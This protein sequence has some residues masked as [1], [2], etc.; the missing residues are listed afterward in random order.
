M[1]LEKI[2]IRKQKSF[3]II[4]RIFCCSNQTKSQ[5]FEPKHGIEYSF[6]KKA[7]R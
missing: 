3:L 4:R 1:Y 7:I 2:E 5:L 6:W